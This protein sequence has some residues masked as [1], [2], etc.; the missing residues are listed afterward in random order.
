[1]KRPPLQVPIAVVVGCIA[2]TLGPRGALALQ[3]ARSQ[4]GLQPRERMAE[5]IL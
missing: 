1:M 3:G 2:M 5:R 4:R